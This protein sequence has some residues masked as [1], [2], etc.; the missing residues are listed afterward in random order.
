M[1]DY[2]YIIIAEMVAPSR[3]V[4]QHGTKYK[5]LYPDGTPSNMEIRHNKNTQCMEIRGSLRRWK[6][7]EG[8]LS[9]FKTPQ[10]FLEVLAEFCDTYGLDF[11]KVLHGTLKAFEVGCAFKTPFK[12]ADIVK[13][14]DSTSGLPPKYTYNKGSIGFENTKARLTIYDKNNKQLR[15][16]T[17]KNKNAAR[18]FEKTKNHFTRIE[19]RFT[20]P[21]ITL[22]LRVNTVND[23]VQAWAALKT[24]YLWFIDSLMPN[25]T[26]AWAPTINFTQ[27]QWTEFLIGRGL[28]AIGVSQ[29]K[30]LLKNTSI[31]SSAKTKIR[32]R[33]HKAI[34]YYNSVCEQDD[35]F[36]K[37]KYLKHAAAQKIK[38][39]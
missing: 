26:R 10:R 34:E 36:D 24:Q 16:K 32:R 31:K 20:N 35:T 28:K 23:M 5:C 2:I 25:G 11:E 29:A 8:Y 9:E 22:K 3:H 21:Q 19:I 7:P 4:K 14:L 17:A 27:A 37:I 38:A 33:D 6:S 30:K 12:L 18:R 39:L 1:I 15:L 13:S